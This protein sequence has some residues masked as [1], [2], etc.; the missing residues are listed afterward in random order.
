[1]CKSL[2]SIVG[3]GQLNVPI[4]IL[5]LA[6]SSFSLKLSEHSDR[7]IELSNQW[8]FVHIVLPQT[9]PI[10]TPT[11]QSFQSYFVFCTLL[12]L[13]GLLCLLGNLSLTF[14]ITS[15]QD[16]RLPNNPWHPQLLLWCPVKA[17]SHCSDN[18]AKR[19][20]SIGW[21]SVCVFCVEQF[22]Q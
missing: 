16:H 2:F 7:N 4:S 11:F 3:F 13:H 22:D 21:M 17:R 18:D 15:Q 20:H 19:T 8:F 12:T 14:T 1:M 6:L 9:S 10:N 5:W